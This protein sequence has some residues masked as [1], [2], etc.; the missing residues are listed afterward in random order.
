MCVCVCVCFII[1]HDKAAVKGDSKWLRIPCR[2]GRLGGPCVGEEAAH[3]SRPIGAIM[4]RRALCGGGMLGRPWVGS[5][6]IAVKPSFGKAPALV[7]GVSCRCYPAF[8][9]FY[10]TMEMKTDRFSSL[11][12]SLQAFML[13]QLTFDHFSCSQASPPPF[14]N[15]LLSILLCNL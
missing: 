13:A 8:C 15:M 6:G 4:A 10:E 1:A 9:G 12:A 3:R 11:F 14:A 5:A 2:L 7:S